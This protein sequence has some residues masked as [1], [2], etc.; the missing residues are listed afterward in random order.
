M[1][2][3]AK[4]SVDKKVAS[5]VLDVFLESRDWKGEVSGKELKS[6]DNKKKRE[7]PRVK[8]FMR[9]H[10]VYDPIESCM[11]IEGI[12]LHGMIEPGV[13]VEGKGKVVFLDFRKKKAFG[14]YVFDGENLDWV[15]MRLT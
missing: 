7:F 10:K 3:F 8:L 15:R 14:K 9:Q 6:E 12:G 13:E 5:Q 1:R 11:K 2:R 4:E